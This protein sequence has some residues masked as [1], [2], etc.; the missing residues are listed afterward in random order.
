MNL[1]EHNIL[2]ACPLSCD[3]DSKEVLGVAGVSDVV[4][5]RNVLFELGREGLTP[6]EEDIVDVDGNDEG[7]GY[8]SSL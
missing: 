5:L 3:T 4:V 1:V 8:L 2:V 6:E 7:V